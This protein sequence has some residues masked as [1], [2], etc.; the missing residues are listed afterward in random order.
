[1]HM[2]TPFF[3]PGPSLPTWNK[4]PP[5]QSKCR[6]LRMTLWLQCIPP[7]AAGPSFWS[8]NRLQRWLQALK[9]LWSM[10][11]C[12]DGIFLL[13]SQLPPEPT[14]MVSL[15][16]LIGAAGTYL[17]ETTDP[18]LQAWNKTKDSLLVSWKLRDSRWK[19]KSYKSSQLLNKV[20]C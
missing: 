14:K 19:I 16:C 13:R 8:W 9:A 7:N 20:S 2:F 3:Q 15:P 11:G 4:I 17:E 1:M 10:E 12:R 5:V 18:L 6:P